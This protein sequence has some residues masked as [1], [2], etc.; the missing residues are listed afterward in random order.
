MNF[1]S[2]DFTIAIRTVC[3]CLWRFWTVQTDRCLALKQV[4][5]RPE[6]AEGTERA[7]KVGG[8]WRSTLIPQPMIHA[9]KRIARIPSQIRAFHDL[10]PV[11]LTVNVTF[12]ITL[13]AGILIDISLS[14]SSRSSSAP[15]PYFSAVAVRVQA[16]VQGTVGV[17]MGWGV[18]GFGV[19]AIS[20]LLPGFQH[21]HENQ[22]D[23]DQERD[24]KDG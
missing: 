9:A 15:R 23:H 8:H 10:T 20:V 21:Q 6:S 22:H 18:G 3:E 24:E 12:R 13:C 11:M 14:R 16:P 17:G 19:V 7:S 1:A 4:H 5:G 2:T